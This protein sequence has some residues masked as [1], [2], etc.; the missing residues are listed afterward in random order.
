VLGPPPPFALLVP[1]ELVPLPLFVGVVA[2][3]VP[4]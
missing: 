3:P 4:V 1:V 2:Q